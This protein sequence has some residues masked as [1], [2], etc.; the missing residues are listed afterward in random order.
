M[1][2]VDYGIEKA[3]NPDIGWCQKHGFMRRI[4]IGQGEAA[5]SFCYGCYVDFFTAN[6]D[7]ATVPQCLAF[8]DRERFLGGK[9]VTRRI[10]PY[11]NLQRKGGYIEVGPGVS[12]SEIE[13]A[14]DALPDQPRF[15]AFELIQKK[16]VMDMDSRPSIETRI[17]A[18]CEVIAW[19]R[20]PLLA[21]DLTPEELAMEGYPNLTPEGFIS[22]F[23][24]QRGPEG[25]GQPRGD[26]TRIEYAI[27]F[28][29]PEQG[30]D[31]QA[32]QPS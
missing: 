3:L 15:L 26:V 25:I 13:D 28:L 14:L 24:E 21:S 11:E 2:D 6:L 27:T 10:Q 7:D 22:E 23:W 19:S 20:G 31:E 30:S 8:S 16:I 1:Y 5:R 4:D 17:M 18:E 29:A 12:A 9:T 32:N